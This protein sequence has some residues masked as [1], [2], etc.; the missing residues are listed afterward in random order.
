MILSFK[1]IEPT[2][3]PGTYKIPAD[4]ITNRDSPVVRSSFQSTSAQ[5]TRFTAAESVFVLRCVRLPSTALCVS[6]SEPAAP[7][8][9]NAAYTFQRNPEALDY[10]PK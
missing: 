1:P 9:Q 6:S 10:E 8:P 7:P 3:G 2:I 4:N 5:V